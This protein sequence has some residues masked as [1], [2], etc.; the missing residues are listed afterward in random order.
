M[1]SK[2]GKS[3]GQKLA[4]KDLGKVNT[5]GRQLNHNETLLHLS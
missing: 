5:L 2:R 3:K 1:K 4:A